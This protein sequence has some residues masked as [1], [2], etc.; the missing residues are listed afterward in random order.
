MSFYG[1]FLV[2]Q[3]IVRSDRLAEALR[4]QQQ[5]HRR[6]GELAVERGLLSP[7]QVEQIH[8]C[9]RSGAEGDRRF[10]EL[11]VA[12]GFVEPDS[13]D[14]LQREQRRGWR[15][16]GEVLV[17]MGALDPGA[18]E[19]CL[20]DFLHLENARHRRIDASLAEAPQ[21]QVVSAAVDLARRWL[22]R[23]GLPEV[24]VLDVR[25][26]PRAVR[27]IAWSGRRDMVGEVEIILILGVSRGALLALAGQTMR[28]GK[29]ERPDL[30][31]PAL[32]E[33]LET[34]TE[35]L[36]N[37]LPD[38]S[39]RCGEVQTFADDGFASLAELISEP[40]LVQIELAHGGP[41]GEAAAAVLTVVTRP[42]AR[43]R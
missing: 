15:R 41:D 26:A 5:A 34:L 7:A 35:L 22:P 8:R 42:P 6:L 29:D 12:L 16:L 2:Q 33:A 28:P 4:Q 11:A 38:A 39:L 9:Q 10:G 40:E 27:G 37:R 43:E 25:A 36:R 18:H 24:R 19:S 21:P 32:A 30:A 31:L 3:G 14:E 20:R 13:M 17:E 23:F 1:E